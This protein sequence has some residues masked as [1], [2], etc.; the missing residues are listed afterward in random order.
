MSVSKLNQKTSGE[1]RIL[2]SDIREIFR[3]QLKSLRTSQGLSQQEL[4]LECD[5]SHAYVGE[6]ERGQQDPSFEALCRMADALD[7][8]IVQ[9]FVAPGEDYLTD[10]L[11]DSIRTVTNEEQVSLRSRMLVESIVDNPYRMAGVWDLSGRILDFNGPVEEIVH[12]DPVELLGEEG[13]SSKI[14]D[15]KREYREWMQDRLRK[16]QESPG[17]YRR[18]MVLLSQDGDHIEIEFTMTPVNRNPDNHPYVLVE[19]QRTEDLEIGS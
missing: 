8:S 1:L 4:S 18:N 10:D 16:M 17:I 12:V 13:W 14:F 5:Y 11:E 9:F 3:S 7:V 15:L 19:G 6:I 2:V